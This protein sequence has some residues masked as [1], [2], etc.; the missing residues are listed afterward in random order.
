MD[1]V[2]IY[3][4]NHWQDNLIAGLIQSTLLGLWVYKKM[5][6]CSKPWCFRIGHH[7]IK[8]THYKT[9]SK[10]ATKAI[11]QDFQHRHFAKHPTQHEFLRRQNG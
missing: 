6:I 4:H 3:F 1:T 5:I 8:G 9:C 2:W 10:H 11:H 7:K